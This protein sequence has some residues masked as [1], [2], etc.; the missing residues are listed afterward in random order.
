MFVYSYQHNISSHSVTVQ[1]VLQRDSKKSISCRAVRFSLDASSIVCG[2]ES[3][4]IL[5]LDV[6][7]SKLKCKLSG[8]H[9]AGISRVLPTDN[10]LVACGDE[11]GN[12]KL[13]DLRQKTA[14]MQ[15]SKHTDFIADLALN[16]KQH[17]L[18]A[19]SGDGT[20][21]VHDLKANKVLARSEDDA[22]DE[23]LSGKLSWMQLYSCCLILVGL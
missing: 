13:W 18:L 8:G 17:A 22:D 15:F 7:T 16:T 6:E 23:L 12:L 14:A 2:Y 4:N 1:K 10:Y 3:G 9:T 11:D 21:S 19:V 20:L 5:Q